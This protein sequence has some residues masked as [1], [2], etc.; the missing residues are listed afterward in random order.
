MKFKFV[1]KIKETAQKIVSS[2]EIRNK[3]FFSLGI[4]IIYRIL[5]AIPV[6]GIKEDSIQK[7]L[8]GSSFTE[9]LA[10]GTSSVIA[11]GLGPY[12]NASVIL[13]LLST[14]IPK[15]EE[16]REQ[17]MQGRKIISMY[18]RY[19]TVPLAI[20]QTFV[21]YSSL[22]API[23]PGGEALIGELSTL[24]FITMASTLT[25]GAVLMMWL[26]E[27]ISES[28]LGG[29]TTLLIFYGIVSGIPYSL[30]RDFYFKD[31]IEIVITLLI[32]V[33]LLA[34]SIYLDQA[35]RR[36]KVVYPKRSQSASKYDNN[37]IPIK[38]TQFG[39]MPVIFAQSLYYF[40]YMISKFVMNKTFGD[41]FVNFVG[42]PENINKMKDVA[43]WIFEKSA[44]PWIQSGGIFILVV[45]FAFFYLT[46]IFEPD[47]QAENLQKSGALI[48]GVRPGKDTAKFLEK[49]SLQLTAIG[50]VALGFLAIL[51]TILTETNLVY[52]QIFSGTGLLIVVGAAMEM[53]RQVKSM[54]VVRSYDKYL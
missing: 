49:A 42:G 43:S 6:V 48:R 26:G 9:V 47:K 16:L 36:V 12:I 25:A 52:A 23:G 24:Q 19:L 4:L 2:Q 8:E 40:P 31:W 28:G 11:I 51:P 34:F 29:G 5:T 27:L 30:K 3:V 41:G 53:K 17:G 44:D 10:M 7:L 15:L 1:D 35:E 18:T 54:I 22:R 50:A 38:L 13:Q 45:L 46:I 21:I 37:Y 20:L 33:A 14:V 32:Y 39:V